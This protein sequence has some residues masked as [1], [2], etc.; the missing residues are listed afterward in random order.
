MQSNVTSIE[1]EAKNTPSHNDT[2]QQQQLDASL[3]L[4]QV[5]S[6]STTNLPNLLAATDSGVQLSTAD[7]EVTTSAEVKVETS[8]LK[9]APSVAVIPVDGN[10][11]KRIVT[12]NGEIEKVTSS[13]SDD[14]SNN[15]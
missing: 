1:D 6:G 11:I 7:E 5:L 12:Q 3:L 13:S 9:R 2:K 15:S 4:Q 14:P 10:T 8:E